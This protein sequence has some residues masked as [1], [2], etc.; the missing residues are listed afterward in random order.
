MANGVRSATPGAE[1]LARVLAHRRDSLG[2]QLAT[3]DP[4]GACALAVRLGLHG[5]LALR[6]STA[7]RAVLEILLAVRALA[8]PRRFLRAVRADSARRTCPVLPALAAGRA[9]SEPVDSWLARVAGTGHEV[10]S[11]A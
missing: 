4:D 1:G 11:L 10:T 8:A 9:L 5:S 6:A 7:G 2:A 3:A